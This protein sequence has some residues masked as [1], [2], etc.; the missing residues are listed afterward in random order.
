M[1]NV[2]VDVIVPVLN[3]ERTLPKCIQSMNEFI[4][5]NAYTNWRLIIVDNGST[6]S[7]PSVMA[8]LMEKFN[9][10]SSMQLPQK[11]R[12][13]AIKKAWMESSAEVRCYMDVDMSTHLSA[14]PNLVNAVLKSNADIAI[15]SR[16]TKGAKVMGRSIK[17]EII[18]RS[19][20]I[21]LKMVFPTIKFKDAQC[22]FKAV[23]QHTALKLLPFV[24]DNSWFFDTELLII[25]NNWKLNIVEIPVLWKDDSD[26]RVNILQTAWDNIKGIIR[27]RFG[28]IPKQVK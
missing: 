24:V 13:R 12:G 25:A 5:S 11:G 19:Y 20:N 8:E 2:S 16:L 28:G 27:L 17:R 21:L 23:N 3:E 10:V 6:D 1:Y 4:Q 15:G 9:F 7:T 22:G 18:S 26:S 14:L